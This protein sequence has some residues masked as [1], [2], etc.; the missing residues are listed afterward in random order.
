MRKRFIVSLTVCLALSFAYA[1]MPAYPLIDM[2]ITIC[3]GR[4]FKTIDEQELI[5]TCSDGKSYRRSTKFGGVREVA[6]SRTSR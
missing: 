6:E 4:G 2:A 5:F 1:L 3:G